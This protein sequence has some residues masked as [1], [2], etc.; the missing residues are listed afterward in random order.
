MNIDKKEYG[1]SVIIPCYNTEQYVEETL[2]SVLD[3]SFK[4]YEIIC[5]NDGSTDG[6]LEI[7]NRYQKLYSN[8]RVISSEHY[9]VAYQR[10]IGVQ[11][12][13]GKYIYY[14]DS[15]DLLKENCLETLYQHSEAD[16]LD[17]LY[18]EA[19]SFYETKEIEEAFPQFLTLYHRH[20]AYDGIYDGRKLYIQ[21]E[22]AGDMKMQ[23]GMQFIRRQF[24]LDNDIKFGMERYFEDNLYTIQVMIKADK[25][26]CVRDDLY[27]R[28]VR[29]N[30]IMTTSENKMRFECYLEVITGLMKILEDEKKESALQEAIYKR[31][32]GTFINIFKDYLKVPEEKKKEFFGDRNSLLYL[33]IGMSFFINIEEANRKE[34]SEKLKKAYKEKSEINA[35]LQNTYVEKSEINAK[36]QSTYAEKSEI[37]A[38]LQKTYEEKSEINAK[39]KKAYEEK[40]ERG[41]KIKELHSEI[42]I[43]KRKFHENKK[44]LKETTEELNEAKQQIELLRKEKEEAEKH[45]LVRVAKKICK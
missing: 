28:R 2:K 16:N 38:K 10:N 4:D 8:I 30:S 33:L 25:A 21:M 29:A 1:I 43:Q 42:E 7:L 18:F 31:I 9:G 39:L 32:R 34:T 37:N 40:T 44:L 22:N 14:V 45:L 20:K 35:K 36:L 6:T 12:A 5:L 23:L 19:D 41:E 15:D 3:Q 26:R 27:L 24:L 11:C 13:R 17:V